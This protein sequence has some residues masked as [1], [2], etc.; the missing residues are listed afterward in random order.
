MGIYNVTYETPE[1]LSM[2]NHKNERK[3]FIDTVNEKI[4]S[5]N[6]LD[7]GFQSTKLFE[8]VVNNKGYYVYRLKNNTVLN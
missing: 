1:L 7:R 4:L 5:G 2:V 8:H 6:V 3:V